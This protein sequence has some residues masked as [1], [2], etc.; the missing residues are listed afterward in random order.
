MN[1]FIFCTFFAIFSLVSCKPAT[2]ENEVEKSLMKDI[3]ERA[4]GLDKKKGVSE[5]SK[6]DEVTSLKQDQTNDRVSRLL[7]CQYYYQQTPLKPL[8]FYKAGINYL[9]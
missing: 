3:L 1:F 2:S 5:I 7:F 4:F 9:I 6:K 8:L